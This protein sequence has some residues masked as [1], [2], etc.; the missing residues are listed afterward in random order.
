[1]KQKFLDEI[2]NSLHIFSVIEKLVKKSIE[3]G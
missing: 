3:M 2:L 1:M